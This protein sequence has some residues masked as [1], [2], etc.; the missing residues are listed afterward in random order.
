[1]LRAC[2]LCLSGVTGLI[3]ED[4]RDNAF[5]EAE[6][7]LDARALALRYKWGFAARRLLDLR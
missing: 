2:L 4:E 1:M 6:V 7:K 5:D 3:R